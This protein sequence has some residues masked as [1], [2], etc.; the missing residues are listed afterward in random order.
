MTDTIQRYL[1]TGGDPQ[2][3]V[4]KATA[5][6]AAYGHFFTVAREDADD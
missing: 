2:L 1:K 5:A 6:C 3:V 4:D